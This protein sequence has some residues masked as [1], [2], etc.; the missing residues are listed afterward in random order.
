MT[1]NMKENTPIVMKAIVMIVMVDM[2]Y[3]YSDGTITSTLSAATTTYSTT[4]T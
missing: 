2:I 4:A 1:G 3:S